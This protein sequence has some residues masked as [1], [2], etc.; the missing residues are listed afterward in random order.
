MTIDVD[1][2]MLGAPELER[3]L[4]RLERQTQRKLVRQSLRASAKRMKGYLIANI[5]SGVPPRVREGDLL[6]AFLGAKVRGYTN[7]GKIKI[8]VVPPT[9][10]ELSIPADDPNYYPVAIEYGHA[11]GGVEVPA[12]PYMRP[13]VDDHAEIETRL[14]AQDLGDRI[15]REASK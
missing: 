12:Y 4:R 2:R 9:R 5:A 13:A 1:I 14:I 15:A 6:G 10:Q 11:S 3:K 8:G 7:R